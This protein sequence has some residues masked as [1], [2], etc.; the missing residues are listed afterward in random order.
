MNK[1]EVKIKKL[2]DNARLPSYATDFAAGA[3]LYANIEND[4]EILPHQRVKIPTGLAIEPPTGIVSVICARSGLSTKFGIALANGVGIV[5]SDYRGEIIVSLVNLSDTAYT[6]HPLDRVAQ[7]I[8]MP[9]CFA[10][11]TLSDT[12]SETERNT[13]GFG[14]TGG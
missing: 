13:G 8:F 1:I 2:C 10:Q 14:S 11:F 9:Y 4:I 3:D 7:I 5:D 6:V 12:L